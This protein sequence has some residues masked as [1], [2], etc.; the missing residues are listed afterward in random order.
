MK[1]ILLWV[2][3]PL[4]LAEVVLVGPWLAERLLRWAA[5]GL[6]I[7]YRQRYTEDWLGELDAVP[8]S[9]TKLAFAV[10]ILIRVP[11]TE[12]ALT[13]RDAVWTLIA[14]RLMSLLVNGLLLIV[15]FLLG[16][17]IKVSRPTV[18]EA[19]RKRQTG[20]NWQLTRVDTPGLS[21]DFVPAYRPA[22]RESAPLDGILP[23]AAT[24]KLRILDVHTVKQ[25]VKLYERFGEVALRDLYAF[26]DAQ[27]EQIRLV[28][29]TV[30]TERYRASRR[31]ST[32]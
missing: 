22:Y 1:D 10:R 23:P 2:V 32:P 14:K 24:A 8:G 17:V 31:R 12:R 15:Q 6:P 9:L 7:E 11:G 20:R 5:C 13:G 29:Q 28:V 3:L 19:I 4:I 21:V 30:L 18:A 16:L 26:T 27:F 25:L